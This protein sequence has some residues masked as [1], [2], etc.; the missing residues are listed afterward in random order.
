MAQFIKQVGRI[1]SLSRGRVPMFIVAMSKSNRA[2]QGLLAFLLSSGD[3]MQVN[4]RRQI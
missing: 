4:M 3:R 2:R 1:T